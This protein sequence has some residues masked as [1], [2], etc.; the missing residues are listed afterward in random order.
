MANYI[1]IDVGAESGRVSLISFRDEKIYLREIYRFPTGGTF[2]PVNGRE[3]F[4]WNIVRFLDEILNG[5]KMS[6]NFGEINSIGID[7]WG[8][9]FALLDRTGMLISLPYH[10][11]DLRTEGMMEYTFKRVGK[12]Y[13]YENTGIQFMQINTLY[14]LLSMVVNNS[15]L[16]EIAETFLMI[17]D[18]FNYWLTG[19]KVCEFT[20]ATTTQFY[21]P[22]KKYWSIELLEKLNIPTK[23]FPEIV[24]P[25][26]ILGDLRESVSNRIGYNVKVIATTSHDT[27]SAVAA[28]PAANKNFAYISSGTWSL[29]GVEVDKPIV[30]ELSF[31]Y[32]FTNEGG[33]NYTYRFLKNVSG[34]WLIQELRREWYIDNRI[35]SYPEIVKIAAEKRGFQYFIDPDYKEFIFLSNL[36]MSERIIRYCKETGQKS[37]KNLG[38]IARTI[39]ESLAF[40]YRWVIEKIEKIIGRRIDTI[41]IVGGGSKNTLLNQLTS[42][43]TRKTVIAGPSEATTIGNAVVQMI[44]MNEIGDLKKARKIISNSFKLQKYTPIIDENI[45]EEAYTKWLEKTGIKVF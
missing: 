1:S 7:T 9:D 22:F 3:A 28:V 27:A 13:I 34:L 15:P 40:K 38:E 35:I 14:Q 18:L 45:V 36:K 37:P 42:D 4:V 23:I 26:T 19:V 11:R 17:P 44:S 16:L 24:G 41:H 5:L 25:G 21:N 12:K 29:V 33:Y 30:N 8:L 2:L 31:K 43:I 6:K 10:Y 20:D 32:N 39:F